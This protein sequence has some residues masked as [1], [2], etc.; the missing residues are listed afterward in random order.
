MSNQQTTGDAV[1]PSGIAEGLSTTS[2]TA[3]PFTPFVFSFWKI[4]SLPAPPTF[5]YPP[6][7]TH[8]LNLVT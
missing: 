5:L 2:K 6:L 4:F 8:L 3:K 1:E 7:M